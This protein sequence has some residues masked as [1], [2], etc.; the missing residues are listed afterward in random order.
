MRI[1][2]VECS[3][4]DVEATKK[5]NSMKKVKNVK[6][7]T[8]KEVQV[9]AF[10]SWHFFLPPLLLSLFA[11]LFYRPSLHYNFQFDDLANITKLFSIRHL[12]FHDLFFN[13]PRW[14]SFWLNTLHYKFG[15][16]NPFTYRLG[17]VISHS[18]TSIMVFFLFYLALSVLKKRPFFS[19]NAFV[20]AATTAMIFLLHPV[21][22]QTVS[23]VIQGQL[24]G[25]AGF[26]IVAISLCFLLLERAKN[27]ITRIVLT[28]V[29]FTLAALSCGTKEIAII[30]PFLLLTFDWF[31]IA[32][33]NMQLLKRRLPLH[34][35]FFITIFG[36]YMYFLKPAFF[37]NIF[38]L[39]M[40]ARNNIGN[41]LTDKSTDKILPLHFFISQ[42]KVILHYLYMFVWPFNISVEYDWKLVKSFFSLDCF[43]PFVALCVLAWAV[44]KELYKDKANTYIFGLIWFFISIAPRSSF[45]PSS[46][47]L[48]DYKTYTG[49]L[50][51]AFLLAVGIIKLML[52]LAEYIQH[53]FYK[54]YRQQINHAF[55]FF[56]ALPLGWTTYER[57]KVWRSGEEFWANVIQNAPLKARAYNNY[58]VALSEKGLYKE[59]IPHYQK[60]ID[61]DN[62]YPDPLN[63]IAV[64]YSFLGDLDKAIEALRRS[65]VIQ[66]HY[67]EAY[68]N[69]A[70]FLIQ[71][72]EYEQAE[73]ALQYALRLRPHYGKAFFNLGKICLYRDKQDEAFEYFKS[74]C[75]K[76]DLDNESGFQLYGHMAMRLKKFEDAIF[77]YSKLIEFKPLKENYFNLAHACFLHQKFEQASAIYQKLLAKDPDERNAW[78]NLGEVYL[79]MNNPQ[80]ALA[81]FQRAQALNHPIPNLPLRMAYC[82]KLLKNFSE[83]ER[84]LNETLKNPAMSE[85]FKMVARNELAQLKTS[86]A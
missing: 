30:S 20:I 16:F 32:Q 74:A 64:A 78:Y 12:T 36:I 9:S 3:K 22:T 6:V 27:S 40:E 79:G 56:L 26:F 14:I 52:F 66:P 50:G 39:K 59:S 51:I 10:H 86:K 70:S 34:A 61:M 72:K 80:Q 47:L 71:K 2:E 81:A 84:L 17:N 18:L 31:F 1:H 7:Q 83:T 28:V 41:V 15:K 76:A 13:G 37:V 55:L 21:Q 49:S 68:N 43:L 48:T 45:I 69:L 42:F 57:N 33:G 46:E 23:Y 75:T 44:I 67:P 24:E 29:F 77:A 5:G 19:R 82:H 63:N 62:A 54:Q 8:I 60:A 35:A 73:K 38:G 58:A 65:I 25:L 11:F 4:N 53:D 85:Q